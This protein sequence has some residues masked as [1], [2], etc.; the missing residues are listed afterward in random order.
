[1]SLAPFQPLNPVNTGGPPSG[2][3]YAPQTQVRV[4]RGQMVTDGHDEVRVVFG[5]L[6]DVQDL[7]RGLRPQD[8]LRRGL[9]VN[10]PHERLVLA[11]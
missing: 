6:H 9:A 10:L 7:L 1:M 11:K 2:S 8:Q 4:L 5:V 3:A